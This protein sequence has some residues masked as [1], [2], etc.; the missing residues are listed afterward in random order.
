MLGFSV[1]LSR[2]LDAE[3]HEYIH[4]MA[5]TGYETVFTS[6]HIPEDDVNVLLTRLRQLTAWCQDEQMQVVADVS[7]DGFE[8]LGWSLQDY[9]TVSSTGLTGLRIDDGINMRD[10]A[11]LSNHM[12]VALNASTLSEQDLTTLR[13]E[14]ANF[15]NI[16]A[17]HN[18]YP[19]PETGLDRQWF[20]S[21][22]Q[23]LHQHGLKVM[24]FVPGDGQRRG[25]LFKGLPTLEEHRQIRP[26]WATVDLLNLD[27]DSVFVGDETV[28]EDTMK[29]IAAYVQTGIIS[30]HVSGLPEKLQGTEWHNRPDVARDVIRLQEA[31]TRQLLSTEPGEVAKSRPVGSLTVDNSRYG[32][33]AG[34]IQITRHD[35]PADKAVNVV[36]RVCQADRVA[37][38]LIDADRAVQL[39]TDD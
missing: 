23:W 5:Q 39:V 14:Q 2:E 17:W 37:L 10:V 11:L 21:K 38:D 13:M 36:G 29:T 26:I 15:D 9:Q 34:E 16:E 4:Q 32:R 7:A 1:Y 28:T 3:T 27:V 22:N 25:P 31:R 24:A 33:Y 8:R 6:L 18:Y 12:L 30:L 35:L 20:L 19:R